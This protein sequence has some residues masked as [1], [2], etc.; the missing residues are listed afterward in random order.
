MRR[1]YALLVFLIGCTCAQA[2]TFSVSNINDAGDGSL[3]QAILAAN[4][5]VAPPHRIVFDAAFPQQGIVELFSSLPLVQVA[6]EIDGAGRSPYLMAFDPTNSF[7]LL[8]TQ[9]GLTVRELSL[10]F[11][12]GSGAGGCLAG[13]GGGNTSVLVLDRVAFSN[14]LTVVSGSSVAAG[15]AVSWSSTALVHIVDSRFDSNSAVSLGTGAATGGA[16]S[17]NGPLRIESSA[18]SGNILNGGLVAGGAIVTSVGLVGAIEIRDSVFTGNTAEP[19]AVS[20]PSGIG[21]ALSLECTSCAITLQRNYFGANRSQNAGAVFVRGNG[22]V[23]TLALHNTSFVGNHATGLGGALFTNAAQLEVRHAT[24]SGNAAPTGGHAFTTQSSVNEWSNSVLARVAEG[25]GG[26]CSIGA[27]ATIA[28]G[29]FRGNTDFSCIV[30]VPGSTPVADFRIIGVNDQQAMPVLAFDSSSPVVDGA[31]SGRCLPDDARS[32][33]RPQDGNNDGSALCDAG[34]FEL[35][36]DDRIF[37]GGF[38]P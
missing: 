29:N 24:F 9:R 36:Y 22:G 8:R 37:Y 30:S 38:E 17:V 2:A 23:A 1:G 4:A 35:P 14:C 3:R 12:R 32:A 10:S 18:F 34:A 19:D 31:D 13:E 15:G 20:S 25:S 26:A 5:A 16:L 21:G 7:P 11:G 27:V 6:L 28:V 33:V